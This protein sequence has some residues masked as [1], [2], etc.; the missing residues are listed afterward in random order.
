MKNINLKIKLVLFSLVIGL[1]SCKDNSNNK[2]NSS[3]NLNSPTQ[4]EVDK[5]KL[6]TVNIQEND[7]LVSPTQIEVN[8]QGVWFA[9]EGTL[10]FIQLIDEKG[11][12]LASGILTTNE[13][14]MTNEP[15]VFSTKLTFDS[16]NSKSGILVIHNDPGSGDGDEAGKKISFQIPIAF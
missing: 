15:V 3:D 10:G 11:T 2:N 1:I 4:E 9:S 12:E 13:N 7:I 5:T 16:K 14:W 6:P 8:S